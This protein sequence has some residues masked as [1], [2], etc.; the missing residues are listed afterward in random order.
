AREGPGAALDLFGDALGDLPDAL[1]RHPA[2][3]LAD[4]AAAGWLTR[5][6]LAAG[7]REAA[8]AAAE[9]MGGLAAANPGYP[10]LGV[11]AAHALGVLA[12]DS[13][14]LADA[15]ERA[16]G[17][18]AR[19]SAAED[20]GVVLLAAGQRAEAA[21]ALDRAMAAYQ[22]A[23][24]A[25][26]AARVRRRLREIGVRHRHWRYAERPVTGWDSLTETERKISL[27]VAQGETNRQVAE[28]MFISVHTVAFHLRHVYRKLGIASRVEL[29]GLAARRRESGA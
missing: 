6:A 9:A 18:W 22:D 4:P 3:L 25:R 8:R 26:D 24:A 12:R 2:L 19:A 7:R 10:G 1:A 28:Q 29:A 11:S 27:L 13:G 16:D 17:T 15:A 21:G 5:T 23:G 20:L 14:A